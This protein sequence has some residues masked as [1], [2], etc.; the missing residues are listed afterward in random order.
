MARSKEED[1]AWESHRL[2]LQSMF[3]DQRLTVNQIRQYM[4]EK[5]NFSKRQ[6]FQ[7]ASVVK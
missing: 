6:A 4:S 3:L 5:Y 1:T 2:E 7:L